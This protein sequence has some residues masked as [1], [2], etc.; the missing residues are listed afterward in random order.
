V[1]LANAVFLSERLPNSRLVVLDSGHFA[2]EET[3]SEYAAAI[4]AA[5]AAHT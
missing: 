4:V 3:P 5:V 2:W 1:P